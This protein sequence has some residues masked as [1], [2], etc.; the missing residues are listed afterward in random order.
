M[1]NNPRSQV[2]TQGTQ[3]SPNRAMLRAVGF[4]DDDFTKPIVGIAN[5]YSTITPCNMGINDLALRAEAGLRTAGAMPQL[6]G[7]ITISDGISMGTEGMKYSLVSR[8]VIADSIETVCNG[9]RMD[10]V[11][12]IGG[13]D[14]NMPGAMIAMARLNIPSIFVYGGTIKPGHYAGEDLT[15]VSAF[16]AVGQYSAG[17]IDEETL[18]GIERNACPGAG[19][20]GGMFTANTMSSAFEA[21]GMSLPYSS[22]MAAVDGE[23]ADSTEESAKV[24]V[25]AIKKQILPSQ[26]LT[27]KA[28]ENAIAVIMAVG[29]STNAVL[30]LLAIANTIGVPLSLD[31]FET[32]RHKVPVL[33]DLKPSGKYVTTNLHAAG[34]IPQVMKIL[35]VNGILHGDA[36]TITGQT[37]AEVLADIPDQ[38]PAGQDVI[39]SWDD[40][41][42]QEGH[43]AVL[44]GNLATEGSVAKISGVKKPVI[45]GPAK[46]FESEEDCLEAI[47]AGKI[48]A[49]DVVVVRYEGPKGGPGMREMLAP[50]SAIIGAG[51]GDSVGLITDGRFSGGTYGLVVGHVAPEAYVGGAIALVQEG[52][53]ITIDAG[54]RLLQLN[55]SEEELAQ[56][57]AQW[58]PPQPRYPRGILAKYAKL[59]SS[60]SLGAVTDIDLF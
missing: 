43:L 47:L 4:G 49:G 27:R 14:K 26:I 33:C 54:K 30:H 28:F 42:Y 18:Y 15:V 41:V 34:G 32:I 55:I 11:L 24:L 29:G 59:V 40:P 1:S 23:K 38:P 58:T 17:K 3:R 22:T 16:E 8:E 5:G 19:S 60:S 21:M 2:I 36:L 6:F 25:E 31:D 20:C 44:K 50:T 46:V 13:C 12:A 57:R 10:G 48:Q 35:L 45:T 9:Q 39:H 53:Q 7:T 37:I 56:R 51:L 52:D